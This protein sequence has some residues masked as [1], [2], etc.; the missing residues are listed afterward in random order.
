MKHGA[1]TLLAATVALLCAS[2]A[3]AGS[4]ALLIGVG[5]YQLPNNDLPALEVGS[6]K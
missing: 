3:L 6:D 2:P 4:K 1:L 5:T